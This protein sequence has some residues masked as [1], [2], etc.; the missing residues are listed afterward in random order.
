MAGRLEGTIGLKFCLLSLF[1]MVV[2]VTR[3]EE[4]NRVL[5]AVGSSIPSKELEIQERFP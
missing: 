3:Y 1:F 2:K 4:R 5:G